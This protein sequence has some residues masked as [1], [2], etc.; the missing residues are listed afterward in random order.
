[1]SSSLVIV[2]IPVVNQ[3]PHDESEKTVEYRALFVEWD[4][5]K[6]IYNEALRDAKRH[7]PAYHELYWQA[8]NLAKP[9]MPPYCAPNDLYSRM[10]AL[11][12]MTMTSRQVDA[13]LKSLAEDFLLFVAFVRDDHLYGDKLREI[14]EAMAKVDKHSHPRH[15]VLNGIAERCNEIAERCNNIA[16]HLTLRRTRF[17][18]DLYNSDDDVRSEESDVNPGR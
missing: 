18:Q 10:L 9:I 4:L 11:E 8:L 7:E 13:S 17:E 5:Y 12:N 15:N 14:E 16:R 6:K 3:F 2:P 1:M